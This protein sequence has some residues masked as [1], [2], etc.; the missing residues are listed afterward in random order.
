[1]VRPTCQRVVP[2]VTLL[3]ALPA[4]RHAPRTWRC[5]CTETRLAAEAAKESVLWRSRTAL[6][7]A[8]EG[9]TVTDGVVVGVGVA[10]GAAGAGAEAGVGAGGSMPSAA[11]AFRRPPVTAL[12]ASAGIGSTPIISAVLIC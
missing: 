1:M 5:S 10:A 7:R 6:S 12:P 11:A 3:R 4:D 9:A 2:A 8:G